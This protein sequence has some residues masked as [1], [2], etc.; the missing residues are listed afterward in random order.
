MAK[1]T[2]CIKNGKPMFRLTLVIGHDE[3][4]KA[5]RKT[6]FGDS[7]KTATGKRDKYLKDIADGLDMSLGGMPLSKAMHIWLFEVKQP[8][9]EL[10]PT[11]FSKYERLYRLYIKD[12][13]IG[14][15]K[16]AEVK[17][18]HVQRLLNALEKSNPKK[19]KQPSVGCSNSQLK[20]ILLVL[21]MFYTYATEQGYTLK[22]PCTSSITI[23]GDKPKLAEVETFSDDEIEKLRYAPLGN[24]LRLI[25]LLALGTGLRQGE[26]LALKYSDIADGM[27]HVTS[28]L[29]KPITV[30]EKG[31]NTTAFSIGEPKTKNSNR[32]VP[33]PKE[34]QK[35]IDYHRKGQLAERLSNGIGGEPTFIFTTPTGG[36]IAAS[37]LYR[38]YVALLEELGIPYKKFHALRHTYASK[39]V[40]A[41]TDINTIQRLMG[42]TKIETTSIYF[43]TDPKQMEEAVQVLNMW[44]K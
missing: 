29:S 25:T 20:D 14:E 7:E 9:N 18:L 27:V 34:L 40:Q 38:I 8:D 17:S 37:A 36:H 2:N 11:S 30:V 19:T 32:Y 33:L 24:R 43:H 22:N 6:F 3:N 4:G 12:S 21:K 28:S 23:P 41:G 42:H 39:L 10:K 5:K 13:S 31:K 15:V 35:E 44:F 26:L 16:V 1:K